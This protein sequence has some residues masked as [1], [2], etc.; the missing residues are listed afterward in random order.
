MKVSIVTVVLN[1]FSSLECC[2]S[3]VFLQDYKNIEYIII[4]GGSTDGT[5]TIINKYNS[6]IAYHTSENDTS[7]YDALNK[8]LAMT[9][10]QII[11]VLNADD[12][13][14]DTGVISSIVA[15]FKLQDCDGVYGNLSFVSKN[16][17]FKVT[18]EWRS[19]PFEA[20]RFRFGW[21]PAHP[22]LYL[23]RAVYEDFGNYSL[24]FGSCSDYDL[25]L[26]V[27]YENKLKAVFLDQFMVVMRAGGLSNG[28]LSKV[29]SAIYH[30]YRI[31]VYHKMPFPVFVV[32]SKKVRKVGQFFIRRPRT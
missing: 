2:I 22:T 15:C 4:D 12:Y 28:S 27:F 17:P 31:L 23:K 7:Y 11:G 16:N 20:L 26:R 32:L 13:L 19:M 25:I 29:L 14:A 10:G 1:S 3:S 8:G 24:D 18:R 9:T 21:M 6:K 5:I 30:D